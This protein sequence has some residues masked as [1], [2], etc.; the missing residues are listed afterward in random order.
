MKLSLRAA[1]LLVLCLAV[2]LL[3]VAGTPAAGGES[4]SAALRSFGNLP[5]SFEPA[6]E[7]GHFLARSGGYTVL[8]GSDESTVAL[9]DR[10]KNSAA[11]LRFAFDR[12]NGKALLE[13]V[14]MLPGV[15]N[16]YLGDQPSQWRIGVKNYARVR[17]R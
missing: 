14:D 2:S 12:A 1:S 6:A 4:H 7:P 15:T 5:L 10:E 13:P 3:C 8:I 9:P 16:Y 11:V 17:A